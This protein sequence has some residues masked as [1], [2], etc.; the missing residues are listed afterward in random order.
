[1][2]NEK[3]SSKTVI[4]PEQLPIWVPGTVLRSSEGLGWREIGLR[5]YQYKS[6]EVEV[7]P[8]DTFM[9]VNYVRGETPL[10]R[11]VD[12]PWN[13]V[14]CRIGHFS[15]LSRCV[16]S[17]WH[18][19][20]PINV[21]HVYLSGSLL[22]RVATEI[23][24]QEVSR[25]DLHDILD[26]LDPVVTHLSNLIAQE[27]DHSAIGG[28]LYVEAL[29]LQ[30]V[31]HLLRNYSTCTFKSTSDL[32]FILPRKSLA[33]V[34]D[35]VDA[36]LHEP[37]TIE[38][39]SNLLGI[40]PW[41]LNRVLRRAGGCSAYAFVVGRRIDRAKH[42]LRNERLALKEVAA[43]C[44]FSDQAHMTRMFKSKLG[45]TPRQYRNEK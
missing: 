35:F 13:R 6:Q 7:P 41:T 25:V 19:T 27:A 44:G 15:L 34:K 16:A 5:T 23:Q 10:D 9:V 20:E 17:D 22:A 30:M 1:M 14:R 2:P 8:L 32:E 3:N 45:I 40:G 31:I 21:T 28:L 43:L 12:G 11:R 39:M 36:H 4:S 33:L 37:I 26:G 38:Q 18:W 29:S 24:K 42:L